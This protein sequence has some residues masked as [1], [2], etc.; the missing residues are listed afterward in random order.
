MI[1]ILAKAREKLTNET[2]LV[3]TCDIDW[4]S[5]YAIGQTLALCKEYSIPLTVFITHKSSV[6]ESAPKELVNIGLHP[7]FMSGSSQGNSIEEVLDFL[8]A[9]HPNAECYRAH[10]Y[11]DVNDVTDHMPKRGILYDSN[12]CTLLDD[13]FPFVHRS[14]IIRFP[15][16]F[17]DG[18]YLYHNSELRLSAIERRL[19]ARG[20]RVINFHPMHLML[21]TPYFQYTRDIKDRVSRKEWGAM[22]E[23]V[24]KKIRY[25][26]DGITSMLREMMETAAVKRSSGELRVMAMSEAYRLLLEVGA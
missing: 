19:F 20:I 4:A 6:I 3:F 25:S 11:Y 7:N 14:G 26:G 13:V 12:V 10:R 24:I 5:D 18:A 23:A 21:N 2:I 22:K 8:F 16:F 15:V 9:L 17:E 1:E